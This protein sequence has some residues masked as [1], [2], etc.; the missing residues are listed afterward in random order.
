MEQI[1]HITIIFDHLEEVHFF[2]DVGMVPYHLAKYFKA[3]LTFL[4]RKSSTIECP[5]HV[6]AISVINV[7]DIPSYIRTHATQ[8][9]LLILFH[10]NTRTIKYGSI[11]KKLNPKG[12]LYLKYDSEESNIAYLHEKPWYHPSYY[13][14]I[15][16]YYRFMPLVNLLSVECRQVYDQMYEFNRAK[17]HYL[18]NGISLDKWKDATDPYS[19]HAKDNIILLVGRHGSYQKNSE[20]IFDLIPQLA[21]IQGWLFILV[22]SATETFLSMY[23]DFVTKYPQYSNTIKLTGNLTNRDEVANLYKRAKI[24]LLPSRSEGFPIVCSEALSQGVVVCMSKELTSSS[25]IT[26]DDQV[27]FRIPRERLDIWAAVISSLM[28]DEEQ[29]ASLSSASQEHFRKTLA[30]ETTI[31]RLAERIVSSW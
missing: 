3:Q 16:F 27:G 19:V 10:I 17:L 24:F 22:G 26:Q 4:Y 30:W 5:F 1:S 9:D 6:P 14:R 15:I 20:M 25:D 2:K 28:A 8:I 12:F 13:K 31:P 7:N 18:P 29:R 11:F 23:R 21:S